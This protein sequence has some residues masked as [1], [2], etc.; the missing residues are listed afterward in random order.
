[1]QSLINI[2]MCKSVTAHIYQKRKSIIYPQNEK[3]LKTQHFQGFEMEN[4]KAQMVTS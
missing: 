4:A 2:T 1:M 3:A